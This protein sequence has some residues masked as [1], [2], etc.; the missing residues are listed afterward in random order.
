MSLPQLN[1]QAHATASLAL[2]DVQTVF[3]VRHLR[4]QL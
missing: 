2:Q 3:L 4:S 1:E